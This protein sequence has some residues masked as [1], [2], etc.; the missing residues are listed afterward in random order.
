MTEKRRDLIFQLTEGNLKLLPLM[1]EL[2]QYERC[3]EVLAWL[4]GR[5]ITG[6]DLWEYYTKIWSNRILSMTQFILMRIDRNKE[7]KPILYGV[8]YGL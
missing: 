7:I 4:V 6:E 3:D 2:T 8:D 5:K 1:H